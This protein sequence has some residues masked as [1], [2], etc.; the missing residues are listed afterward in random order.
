MARDNAGKKQ[1]TGQVNTNNQRIGQ[2][3]SNMDRAAGKE[4][5]SIDSL[6]ANPGLG[7]DFLDT[8]RARNADIMDST[9]GGAQDALVRN[10]AAQG[11]GAD[12]AGLY[13]QTAALAREKA[14]TLNSADLDYNLKDATAKYATRQ[15]LP[16]MYSGLAGLF[17]GQATSLGGQN[18]SLIGGRMSADNSP[19]FGQQMLLAGMSGASNVAGA[20]AGKKG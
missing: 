10:S 3:D 9:F 18:A 8:S 14:R 20:Y 11:H 5:G 19:T 7:Q 13:P 17:G 6:A 1:E 12:D 4:E 15:S 16:G 2:D